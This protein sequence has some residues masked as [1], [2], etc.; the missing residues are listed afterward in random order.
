VTD[1]DLARADPQSRTAYLDAYAVGY[2]DGLDAG[3]R[4]L[5]NEWRGLMG[6]SA[7]VARLIAEAGPYADLADRRGDHERA[8]RHRALLAERGIA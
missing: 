3:R 8:A 5:E 1:L 2:L 7:A 4:E 6:V